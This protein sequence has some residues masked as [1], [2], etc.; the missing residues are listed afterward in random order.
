MKKFPGTLTR[1]EKGGRRYQL[2]AEQ[3]A[4]LVRWFPE[5]ENSRLM[6]SSG[7]SHSTLHRFARELGLVKSE[8]GF[9]GIKKR[10]ALRVKRLCERNGYYASLRGRRPSESCM[11]ASSRMWHEIRSG[12]RP[13][14][15]HIMKRDHPSKY[16]QWIRRQSESRKKL[17]RQERARLVFGLERKTRLR[18]VV[19]QPYTKSQ[20]SHRYNAL[21]RG[22]SYMEDCSEGSGYR[23]VIF[24]DES[25]RR[26]LKFEENLMKD[27]FRVVEWKE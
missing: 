27:G 16:R 4:W 22:Y 2:T 8:K 6:K 9:R 11:E 26:S 13:H 1:S 17:I 10:Q 3:S 23:Y 20:T 25:T 7:M 24:Y 5:V 15:L 21:R 14:P 12:T 19:L 18:V